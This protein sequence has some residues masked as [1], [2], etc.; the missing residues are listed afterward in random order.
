MLKNLDCKK[1]NRVLHR[2]I[3]GKEKIVEAQ[4]ELTFRCNLNCRHCYLAR[5]SDKKELSTKEIF[6]ILDQLRKQGCFWLC[7]T[8]GEPLIR[9]DFLDI[10]AYAKD[11]GF[12]INL[13]TNGTL[14]TKEIADYL[15]KYPPYTIEI[16]LNAIT[17]KTYEAITQVPDSFDKVMQ[18][19]KF[20]KQRNLPL[21]LKCNGMNINK[22]EILKI[23]EFTENLLGKG[24]FRFDPVIMPKMDGSREPCNLRLTPD[25]I[26]EI[27]YLDS[28]MQEQCKKNIK[29]PENEK[30][31][32]EQ[33]L[34]TNHLYP[35][36][37]G[38]TTCHIDAY[39]YLKICQVSKEPCY[40]LR[41][42]RLKEAFDTLLNQLKDIK[43]ATDS[44]C[45]RCK[46]FYLCRQCP[47]RALLENND[48]EKPVE[49]FC[50]IAQRIRR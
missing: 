45:R 44:K 29:F 49:Y 19:I 34:N 20:I 3:E 21:T 35:C 6:G 16:T 38:R 27:E 37:F 2:K 33:L 15:K 23:K 9:K 40:D 12:L 50:E 24:K 43:W 4:W 47:A 1:F 8:G 11:K 13:F 17:K 26:R 18:G 25:E 42:F 46:I 7:L 36:A 41:R 31:W 48:A 5:D 22:N 28:D 39:G 32:Y 30:D 10:Y 14:L